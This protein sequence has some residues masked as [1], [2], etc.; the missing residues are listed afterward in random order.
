LEHSFFG[1]NF[2]GINGGGLSLVITQSQPILRNIT[3]IGNSA[4]N[5]YGGGA[6]LSHYIDTSANASSLPYISSCNWTNNKALLGGGGLYLNLYGVNSPP[7]QSFTIDS[8]SF[9]RNIV[10]YI[11]NGGGLA[12]NSFGGNNLLNRA[13]AITASDF[14]MNNASFGAGLFLVNTVSYIAVSNFTG[15][16][17]RFSGGSLF[18]NGSAVSLSSVTL[19][20][21][22]AW[23]SAQEIYCYRSQMTFESV[24]FNNGSLVGAVLC[25]NCSYAGTDLNDDNSEQCLEIPGPNPDPPFW[26]LTKPAFIGVIVAIV[27][28]GILIL[29]LIIWGVRRKLRGDYQSF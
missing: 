23:E 16:Y 7:L 5:G 9:V 17:A 26:G 19:N 15:N 4:L 14:T 11:G 8:N 25:V 3:F 12:V 28:G 24:T 13:V 20:N 10:Q 18:T 29:S 21:N 22:E 2:A 1:T 27:V 6:Y